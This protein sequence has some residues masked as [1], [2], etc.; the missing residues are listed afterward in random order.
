MMADKSEMFTP[1]KSKPA[2]EICQDGENQENNANFSNSVDKIPHGLTAKKNR[3]KSFSH[4]TTNNSNTMKITPKN[5]PLTAPRNNVLNSRPIGSFTDAKKSLTKQLNLSLREGKENSPLHSIAPMKKIDNETIINEDYNNT[6]NGEEDQSIFLASPLI[7]SKRS[8]IGESKSPHKHAKFDN[9]VIEIGEEGAEEDNNSILISFNES[10]IFED[11]EDEIPKEINGNG[12]TNENEEQLS[13]IEQT[14]IDELFFDKSLESISEEP[15]PITPSRLT[16]PAANDPTTEQRSRIANESGLLLDTTK[17]PSVDE[18]YIT[19]S[20]LSQHNNSKLLENLNDEEDEQEAQEEQTELKEQEQENKDEELKNVDVEDFDVENIQLSPEPTRL[21]HSSANHILASPKSRPFF[22]ISQVHEIQQDFKNEVDKLQ[23]H[24]D[25]K[26]SQLMELTEKFNSSKIEIS[27]LNDLKISLELDKKQLNHKNELFQME[28]DLFKHDINELEALLKTKEE[29]LKNH[30]A[31]V[32]SFQDRVNELTN[33][34]TEKEESLEAL[35]NESKELRSQ[36]QEAENSIKSK[37]DEKDQLLSR[38]QV[39]LNKIDELKLQIEDQLKVHESL[40]ST[41]ESKDSII[42]EKTNNL[43]SFQENFTNQNEILN[44]LEVQNKDLTTTI[45][46]NNVK[47]SSLQDELNSKIG[48]LNSNQI[49]LIE[50]QKQVNLQNSI[51]LGLKGG[52]CSLNFESNKLKQE[53]EEYLS[54][55]ESLTNDFNETKELIIIREAEVNEL[56][57]E[58]KASKEEVEKLKKLINSKEIR[59]EELNVAIGN[60]ISEIDEKND[61]IQELDEELQKQEQDHINEL[62]SFHQEMSNVQNILTSRSNELFKLKEERDVLIKEYDSLNYE[63][64]SIKDEFQDSETRIDNLKVKLQELRLKNHE[65]ETMVEKLKKE[66]NSLEKETDKRLQQLAEDLYIQYSKKHEQK[67]QVLKKG[68]ETKWQSKLSKL[69][70]ENE[71]LKREIEG[72]TS[73][74]EKE[75][76]EKNEIIKLWDKLKD[77]ETPAAASPKPE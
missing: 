24:L 50:L 57:I 48:E 25:D 66:K 38:E 27:K 40:L 71:K 29:K 15:K 21:N 61:K 17:S 12:N 1:I 63:Y 67:V 60:K 62:E 77:T 52:V 42:S 74:L 69:E 3:R 65:L 55:I 68:Y 10:S 22:T 31:A 39:L 53:N 18:S 58:L 20:P 54:Q 45:N 6:V 33:T 49:E 47:I 11:K 32:D 7:G 4:Q 51:I 34:I 19:A 13:R 2:F 37:N 70:T 30:K 46:E 64:K 73:Q 56:N 8:S 26:N 41:I 43:N 75:Q 72:L 14:D 44:K 28:F 16:E 36:L 59:E 35:Q 9:S 5:F 76:L 23:L